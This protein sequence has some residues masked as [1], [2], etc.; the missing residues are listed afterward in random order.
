MTDGIRIA[1]R[2]DDILEIV[3][4]LPAQGNALSPPM[5]TAI[6]A[7]IDAMP[8]TIRALYLHAE[9]ADFC[10]GRTPVLPPAGSRATALDL[11]QL[12]ADP[13]LDFYQRLRE[14]P[15]PVVMAVQGRAAGVGCALAG[16]AD[17][18]IASD[19]AVFSVPEMDKDVAPTLVMAALG[20]RLP[21]AALARLVFTRDPVGAAEAKAIGLIGVTCA[22]DQLYLQAEA[23]LAKLGRNSVPVVRG[24]KS[25]LNH[26]PEM[27][28]AARREAAALINCV[29][30]AEK[31]R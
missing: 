16:L 7:A 20:D 1:A 22:A 23:L 25:F 27:S 18:C 30:T 26:H 21:R 19:D 10:T 24:V 12:I 5:A 3:L 14:V 13:V 17:I 29:V 2:G 6:G 9:G 8:P 31:Y 15:V 11:R 4:A 28:F